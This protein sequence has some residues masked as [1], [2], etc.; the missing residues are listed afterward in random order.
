MGLSINPLT[1]IKG[2]YGDIVGGPPT[3]PNDTPAGQAATGVEGNV[4]GTN[5]N[6][7]PT[8]APQAGADPAAQQAAADAA[9]KKDAADAARAAAINTAMNNPANQAA[10]KAKF[11]PGSG[12]TP[13]DV[14]AFL[15][16]LDPNVAAALAQSDAAQTALT[17]AQGAVPTS[18]DPRLLTSAPTVAPAPV[19]AAPQITGTPNVG[20]APVVS[21]APINP[22]AVPQVSGSNYAAAIIDP[23]SIPNAVAGG[24]SG[25]GVT[26]TTIDPTNL[27]INPGDVPDIDISGSVGRQAQLQALSLD[28]TAATGSAPSAAQIL[29]QQGVDQ[30]VGSAYGL[31]ASLQ[32]RNPG[33]ALRQGVQSAADLTQKSVATSAALRATEMATARGQFGDLASQIAA[34]DIQVAQSNQTKNLQVA[35]TN[36]NDKIDVLKAN[37]TAQLNAGIASAANATA[38]SIATLQAQTTVAVANMN[39][40][41]TIDIANQTAQ[42]DASKANQ[43]NALAAQTT[44]AINTLQTLLANQANQQNANDTNAANALAVQIEQAQEALKVAQSNQQALLAASQSNA[45]NAT[46]VNI[47]QAQLDSSTG[48]FDANQ[49]KSIEQ[50]NQ[51]ATLTEQQLN[52]AYQLGLQGNALNAAALGVKTAADAA[53]AQAAYNAGYANFLLGAGKIAAGAGAGGSGG[54][55]PT[56]GANGAPIIS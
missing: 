16:T 26:A 56:V 19:I 20:P 52:N 23:N 40:S 32:G 54:T 13:A 15:A 44:N 50:G 25:A 10:I 55:T 34:G 2:L 51:G 43:A 3:N 4:E 48:Q 29:L 18:I 22:S 47:T 5:A 11:P 35:I 28:Q 21:A 41:V 7:A 17:Q 24:A 9:A 8:D 37:Q 33:D 39:K 1:D 49:I 6:F 45:T 36:L 12:A 38:A 31:A 53:A 14:N 30:S 42:N 46:N 27:K